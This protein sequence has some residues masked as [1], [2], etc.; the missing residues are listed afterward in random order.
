MTGRR[1]ACS[2]AS[3]SP[4]RRPARRGASTPAGWLRSRRWSPRRYP[5]SR[6]DTSPRSRSA[7]PP[8]HSSADSRA[9]ATSTPRTH[10]RRRRAPRPGADARRF[11]KRSTRRGFPRWIAAAPSR[12]VRALGGVSGRDSFVVSVPRNSQ[13]P[14]GRGT[15]LCAILSSTAIKESLHEVPRSYR[16]GCAD[17]RHHCVRTDTRLR[18]TARSW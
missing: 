1:P 11:P 12:T 13:L 15:G 5:E 14:R 9:P 16:A 17:V 10:Q 6:Q 2:S 3:S 8:F 18:L 4:R 7:A